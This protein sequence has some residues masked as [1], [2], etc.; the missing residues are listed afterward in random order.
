MGQLSRRV[1]TP[2]EEHSTAAKHVLRYLSGTKE[3]KLR[4]A[5]GSGDLSGYV[6]ASYAEDEQRRSTT[7]IVMFMGDAALV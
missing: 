6:D 7:S 3:Y 4:L 1:A 5:D 2:S